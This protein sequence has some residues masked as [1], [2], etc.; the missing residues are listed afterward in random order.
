MQAIKDGHFLMPP[1]DICTLVFNGLDKWAS[2]NDPQYPEGR[3]DYFQQVC[4]VCE[5]ASA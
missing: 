1:E 5:R 4:P 2:L 3:T